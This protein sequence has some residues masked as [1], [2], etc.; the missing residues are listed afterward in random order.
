MIVGGLAA[1][2]F[3]RAFTVFHTIFFPGKD[4][5][6]FDPMTDPVILILP[7]A[8]FRSCAILILA[9]VFVVFKFILQIAWVPS[10]SMETTLPTKSVLVGLHL[11]Y[12]VADPVPQRGDIV[13]FWSDELNKLLVKRVVGLPGDD[14]AFR[15]GYTY[16]NGEMLDEAYLPRQG[17]TQSNASFQVP[18]GCVFFMGDNRTGSNDARFWNE[19]Y[20]S[21]DHIRA[22]VM[23]GISVLPDNSWRGVR[24]IH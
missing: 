20:I 9:A 22:R 18:E 24:V 2:D 6:L 3:D 8:F 15:D 23:V 14:I 7:E 11:P 17:I 5:W 12:I 4:N 16:V 19:P 1:L 13:T 21:V 10:G